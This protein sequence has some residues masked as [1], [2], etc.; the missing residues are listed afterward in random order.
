MIFL[1]VMTTLVTSLMTITL[2]KEQHKITKKKH[3]K[4]LKKLKSYFLRRQQKYISFKQNNY[5]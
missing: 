5:L 2:K 1:N 4:K 3:F